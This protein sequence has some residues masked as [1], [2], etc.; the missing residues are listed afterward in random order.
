M[1]TLGKTLKQLRTNAGL[2]QRE[3][4]KALGYKTPQLISNNERDISHPPI[5]SIRKLAKLYNVDADSLF[6][7]V[8]DEVIR[9]E[10][11]KLNHKWRSCK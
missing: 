5:N 4:A 1:Q 9:R 8:R 6:G 7:L 10:T 3:V 11:D 2:S